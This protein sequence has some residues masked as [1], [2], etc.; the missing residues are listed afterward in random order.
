MNTKILL[1]VFVFFLVLT[2]CSMHIPFFWDGTFF[3]GLSLYFYENGYNGFIAPQANDTGGF[4]LFSAYLT[5]MWKC[6]GKTLWVSH[7]AMLPFLIGIAYEYF[8][9][10]KRFISTNMIALSMLLLVIEPVFLT[11]SLLMGYDIVITCFFLLALNALYDDK[12]FIFSIAILLL[13]M[14]SVRGV[15]LAGALFMID[16]L[17][18]RNIGFSGIRLYLPTVLL[19][20]CWTFYHHS[21][22]GWY[23]FSPVRESNA[24]QLGGI[25][26]MLR[27]LAYIGWKN[28]DL[29]RI[30]LWAL[31]ILAMAYH[32]RKKTLPLMKEL[33]QMVFI[34]LVVLSACMILIKNPIG[35]KYFL[36][37]FLLLNIA[38]CYVIDRFENKNSKRILFALIAIS[39]VAGNFTM[40]PQRYGNSWD[41]SLKIIPYFSMNKQMH[42]YILSSK[43]NADEIGT[44]FPFTSDSRAAYMTNASYHYVDIEDQPVSNFRYFLYSNVINTNRIAELEAIQKTW[45][46]EK[47]F[48]KGMVVLTLYRN[49]GPSPF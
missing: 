30:T 49:P 48:E 18:N 43:I 28:V 11:Q 29:G 10:A 38:A 21:Q 7:F 33:L 19:L 40:Y 15:M 20:I 31:F 14:I 8:K 45:I 3:S 4:P 47:K 34:P 46:E 32:L 44:Q 41:S 26:M 13:C 1:P 2:F 42:E 6:F 17:R 23:I 22:T 24:E 36:T 5:F 35:H 37:I 16:I 27:Q 9:L 12:K 25:K 39:L